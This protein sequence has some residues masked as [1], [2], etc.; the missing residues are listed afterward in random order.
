MQ[1]AAP[2][3]TAARPHEPGPNAVSPINRSTMA[4]KKP[5]GRRANPRIRI[6]LQVLKVRAGVARARR[7]RSGGSLPSAAQAG[8]GRCA[9]DP[10]LVRPS[11]SAPAVWWRLGVGVTVTTANRPPDGRTAVGVSPAP[12]HDQQHFARSNRPAGL[13]GDLPGGQ[14]PPDQGWLRRVATLV[15][16]SSRAEETGRPPTWQSAR[17]SAR[18]VG[19]RG[20]PPLDQQAA[21]RVPLVSGRLAAAPSAAN[22][23][24]PSQQ[25][26]HF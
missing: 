7:P 6:V 13:P 22:P 12:L 10:A 1:R 15:E 11:A 18:A 9:L 2:D 16:T 23:R 26:F 4:S 3:E 8:A 24:R 25:R 20:P 5:P 14:R 17:P 21:V 19:G